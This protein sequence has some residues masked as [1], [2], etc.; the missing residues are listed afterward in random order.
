LS[1]GGGSLRVAM[2]PFVSQRG[3][4]RAAELLELDAAQMSQSYSDRLTRVIRTLG[5]GFADDAVNVVLAHAM[6]R[7]GTMGGGERDAQTVFEYGIDTMAFDPSTS[8]V[9]LGHLHRQQQL[10]G[11]CPV[12]YSGSPIAVDFGEHR[13][14]PGVLVVEAE[15]GR[16]ATARPVPLHSPR[17]LVTLTDTVEG[18]RAIAPTLGDELV[19]VVVTEPARAG[20]AEE[21]RAILPN[22]VDIRVQAPVAG[23]GGDAVGPP[24]SRLGASPHDQFSRYLREQHVA[25]ERLSALFAALLDEELAARRQEGAA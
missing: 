19:K 25:D 10:P 13:N 14:L 12:W 16:P 18:L 1:V 22:A 3:V 9:A 15:P 4:V 17:G 6:V 8:Y 11:P 7:G 20:L 21:V 24:P 23:S 2:V 5:A